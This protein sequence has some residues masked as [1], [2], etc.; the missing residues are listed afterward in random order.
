MRNELRGKSGSRETN[1]GVTSNPQETMAALARFKHEKVIS[2]QAVKAGE[3]GF[4]DGSDEKRERGES[5]PTAAQRG[6]QRRAEVRSTAKRV[7]PM[8]RKNRN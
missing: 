5:T 4:A 6:V 1:C 8:S 2:A 3:G 7:M